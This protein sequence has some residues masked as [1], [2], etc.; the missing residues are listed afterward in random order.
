MVSKEN[1]AQEALLAAAHTLLTPRGAFHEESVEVAIDMLDGK[2]N[3]KVREIVWLRKYD[4]SKSVGGEGFMASCRRFVAWV[5]FVEC[6]R[7]LPS[8]LE[9]VYL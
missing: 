2:D 5:A 9:N 7:L 8:Q 6:S 3:E 1:D 4:G